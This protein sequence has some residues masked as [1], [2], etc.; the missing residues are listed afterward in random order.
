MMTQT[1]QTDTKGGNTE[2]GYVVFTKNA[3]PS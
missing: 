1:K 3:K 2:K